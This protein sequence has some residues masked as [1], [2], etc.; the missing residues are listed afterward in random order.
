LAEIEAFINDRPLA[1][2]PNTDL[3]DAIPISPSM[4]MHGRLLKQLPA[5]SSLGKSAE[6]TIF[7]RWRDRQALLEQSWQ[8]WKKEYLFSL[9]RFQKWEKDGPKLAKGQVVLI[10]TENTPRDTWPLARVTDF[11]TSEWLEV[12]P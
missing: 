4:L 12:T 7:S 3:T 5:V 2:V 11:P 8:K 1:L 10:A 6:K 9:T